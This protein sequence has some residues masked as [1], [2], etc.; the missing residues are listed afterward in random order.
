[1]EPPYP[2]AFT[3]PRWHYKLFNASPAGARLRKQ[4]EV[5]LRPIATLVA[6][7]AERAS[8]SAAEDAVVDLDALSVSP[9]QQV[10]SLLPLQ[11]LL[12]ELEFRP[13]PERALHESEV[14]LRCR[15]RDQ[16]DRVPAGA[17]SWQ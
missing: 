1:M 16:G 3:L 11:A 8:P 17:R 7:E 2:T 10:G 14:P 4:R 9:G 15:D 12:Q 5:R 6:R 13:D